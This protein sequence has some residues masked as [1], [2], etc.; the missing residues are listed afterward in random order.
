MKQGLLG[1]GAFR[2]WFTVKV[3]G[4]YVMLHS[5]QLCC[6]RVSVPCCSWVSSSGTSIDTSSE[7]DNENSHC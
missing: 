4:I 5:L 6:M 2:V 1:F 7:E 3:F